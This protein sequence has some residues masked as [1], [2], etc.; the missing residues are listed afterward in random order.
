MHSCIFQYIDKYTHVRILEKCGVSHLM[1]CCNKSGHNVK[2][3]LLTTI[4]LRIY[5]HLRYLN[6]RKHDLKSQVCSTRDSLI[7]YLVQ[8]FIC[9]LNGKG[10]KVMLK[11][12]RQLYTPCLH[13]K[14]YHLYVEIACSMLEIAFQR[15]IDV[16]LDTYFEVRKLPY[17]VKRLYEMLIHFFASKTSCLSLLYIYIKFIF[18]MRFFSYWS[19]HLLDICCRKVSFG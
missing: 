7:L 11:K 14:F 13:I 17:P 4:L 5:I 10:N 9:L 16:I 3:F 1:G 18:R 19:F 6:C 8:Y 15:H 12:R 2:S